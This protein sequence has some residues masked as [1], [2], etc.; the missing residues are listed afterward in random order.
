MYSCKALGPPTLVTPNGRIEKLVH[1]ST[2]LTVEKMF[3]K[4]KCLERVSNVSYGSLEN[5][6]KKKMIHFF[7]FL[8]SSDFETKYFGHFFLLLISTIISFTTCSL[9]PSPV[10]S[11]PLV[12]ILVNFGKFGGNFICCTKVGKLFGYEMK[13]NT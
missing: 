1:Q 2:N 12:N 5:A 4:K 9:N 3:S 7:T 11:I 13:T 6:P 8:I 10:E